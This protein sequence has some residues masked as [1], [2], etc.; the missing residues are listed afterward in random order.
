MSLKKLPEIR[1]D[2]RLAKA[3][4]DLRPDA[5]DRW[6]PAVCAKAG[7]DA[8]AS[9]SIYDS[10]GENW[11]GTG[12]TSKRISAA[13]RSIGAKDV[14]VNINSPGGDFFEGMAIYNLLREHQGKVTV[15]VLGVAASVASVIA[16]AGDEILIGDGA[17]FMIHN[18]WAVAVGNRHDMLDSAKLLEPFDAAMAAL[19]AHQTGMSTAE[20]AI[21]MD[22]ETWIGA[23]QAVDDGFA[24]GLLPSSEI[25]KSTQA[26]TKTK[27]LALIEASMAKAGFSRNSRRDTFK[28]LFS[29][30]PGAA[31]DATPS[32]GPEVAASLQSLLNT[33]RA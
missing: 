17:F 27:P 31:E 1:A 4:F 12:I 30:T 13:L 24:T 3:G 10:I 5:V 33:L 25:T 16:M 21:M 29:G 6:E 32:A 20:A 7:D 26:S 22:K 15:R 23:Q 14:V 19:Y 8:E 28:A 9:I 2:H 11:E 18:A